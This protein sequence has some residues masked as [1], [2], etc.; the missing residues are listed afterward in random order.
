VKQTY[1]FFSFFKAHRP[2]E[3][4]QY[5]LFKAQRNAYWFLIVA[6]LLWSFYES[7]H[8]LIHKTTLN[9]MPCTILVAAVLIQT[10][11]QLILSRNAVKDDEES[12]EAVPYR[13]LIIL[14]VSTAVIA[15][16]VAFTVMLAGVAL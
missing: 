7:A 8:T 10:V 16:V 14:L 12:F 15:V 9:I 6:M 3:M 2:D 13:I 4:E 5:I 11:T 1:R